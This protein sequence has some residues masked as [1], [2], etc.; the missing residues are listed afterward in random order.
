MPKGVTRCD[1]PFHEYHAPGQSCWFEL[2]YRL[3]AHVYQRASRHVDLSLSAAAIRVIPWDATRMR[4]VVAGTLSR[5]ELHVRV[6][7]RTDRALKTLISQNSSDR[8][9]G[10]ER[11]RHPSMQRG[12]LAAL[13]HRRLSVMYLA[14]TSMAPVHCCS[15][16][17]CG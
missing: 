11:R 7:H 1:C 4:I 10:H 2:R 15:C 6:G 3:Q 13:N 16:P 17:D 8:R 9:V 12:E 5:S 14:Q